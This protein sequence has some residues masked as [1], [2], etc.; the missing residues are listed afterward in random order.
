MLCKQKIYML[1]F[2]EENLVGVDYEKWTPFK[3]ILIR[4]DSTFYRAVCPYS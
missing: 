1:F 3:T 4:W 2:H